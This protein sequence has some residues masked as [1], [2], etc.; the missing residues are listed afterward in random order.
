MNSTSFKIASR[1]LFSKKTRNVINLISGISLVVVACVTAAMI[2]LLSAFNGIEEL[3]DG[4]YNKFDPDISI[5]SQEGKVLFD[6]NLDLASIEKINGVLY[7]SS[8]IEE[9]AIIS[10]GDSKKSLCKLIGIDT[11]Y[12]KLSG[13]KENV[14]ASPKISP[15]SR[16]K[17]CPT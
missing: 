8:V 14:S 6:D 3:V 1:Y 9:T 7:I 10:K 17:V 12:V 5:T 15:F 16:L 13:I 11:T 4:L 2:I